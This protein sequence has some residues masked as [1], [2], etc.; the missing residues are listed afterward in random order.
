MKLTAFSTL[1]QRNT[2]DFDALVNSWRRREWWERA[3]RIAKKARAIFNRNAYDFDEESERIIGGLWAIVAAVVTIG[4]G[5]IYAFRVETP[6]EW[7][8]TMYRVVMF[9]IAPYVLWGVFHAV[10][11]VNSARKEIAAK[12]DQPSALIP[13]RMGC[14]IEQ[15]VDE[16]I[17]E[18]SPFGK[19]LKRVQGIQQRAM[20]I[21]T[22]FDERLKASGAVYLQDGRARAQNVVL[23]AEAAQVTLLEFRARVEAAIAECRATLRDLE[24]TLRD[25]EL[26]RE[27]HELDQEAGNLEAQAERVIAETVTSLKG[28]MAAISTDVTTRFIAVKA[29]LDVEDPNTQPSKALFALGRNA[30]NLEH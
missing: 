4:G 1:L 10:C 26:L 9:C 5:V 3:A 29:N 17:G 19:E 18:E 20:R 14:A 7:L 30:E 21:R 15:L 16:L 28:R 11:A 6:I 12:N 8:L 24:P 2:T 22:Q 25:L 27:M 23:K 13:R